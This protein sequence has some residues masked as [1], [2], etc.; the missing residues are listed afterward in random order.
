MKTQSRDKR[1]IYNVNIMKGAL[2]KRS[3]IPS[4]G[5]VEIYSI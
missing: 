2:K 5:Y 3:L 1:F 4:H